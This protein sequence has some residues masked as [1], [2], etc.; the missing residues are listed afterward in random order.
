MDRSRLPDPDIRVD[1]APMRVA[2]YLAYA[3]AY[4]LTLMT[5]V[6][7]VAVELHSSYLG[8]PDGAESV[9]T[10]LALEPG[11]APRT[12]TE[13][14]L[15]TE[16]PVADERQRCLYDHLAELAELVASHTGGEVTIDVADAAIETVDAA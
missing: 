1:G 7:D 5:T 13:R 15:A 9:A 2:C 12:W 14:H 6:L 11:A 16:L 8:H 4:Q 10:H 3:G